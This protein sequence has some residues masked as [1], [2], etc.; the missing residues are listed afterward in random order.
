MGLT[1]V[2]A[3]CRGGHFTPVDIEDIIPTGDGLEEEFWV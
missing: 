3:H 1:T 2:E